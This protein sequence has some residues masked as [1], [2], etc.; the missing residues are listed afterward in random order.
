MPPR[1]ASIAFP[2]GTRAGMRAQA[3]CLVQEGD[4]PIEITWKKDGKVIVSNP[5]L[6]ISNI[7]PYTSILVVKNASGNHTGNYTCIASNMVRESKQSASLIVRGTKEF[8]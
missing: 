1:L 5:F 6:S 7:D 8:L 4:Q 2:E 3:T